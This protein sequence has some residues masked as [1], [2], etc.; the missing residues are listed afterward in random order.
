MNN[1]RKPPHLKIISGT[2]QPC[3]AE[4]APAAA[5]RLPIEE[6]GEPSS[7]PAP[8]EVGAPP[9]WLPNAAAKSEWKRLGPILAARGMLNEI[10]ISL[11]A[12]LC[13]LYGKLVSEWK[14]PAGPTAHLVSQYRS[15]CITLGLVPGGPGGPRP[16]AGRPPIEKPNKETHADEKPANRFAK[17][18]QP[19]SA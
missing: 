11:F 15:I 8:F 7:P 12:Q 19:E 10:N 4:P 14:S 3:R 5:P 13:S 17:F 2:N 9:K 1:P 6:F 18:R 16:G